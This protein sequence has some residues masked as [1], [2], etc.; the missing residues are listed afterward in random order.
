MYDVSILQDP[1]YKKNGLEAL[2]ESE[3]LKQQQH[4]Q[5]SNSFED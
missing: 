1:F 5:E 4:E 3:R 2:I